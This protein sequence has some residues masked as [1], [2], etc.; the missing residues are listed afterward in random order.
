MLDK[1]LNTVLKHIIKIVRGNAKLFERFYHILRVWWKKQRRGLWGDKFWKNEDFLRRCLH[2]L[3]PFWISLVL[4]DW[5]IFICYDSHQLFFC[6]YLF[7]IV[8]VCFTRKNP[9]WN[10]SNGKSLFQNQLISSNFCFYMLLK[11]HDLF[12]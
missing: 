3:Q 8:A 5:F 12:S 10:P 11:I 4:I 6:Y 9:T 2:C 1:F 7:L